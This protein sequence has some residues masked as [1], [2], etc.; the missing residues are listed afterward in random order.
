M[1]YEIKHQKTNATIFSGEYESLIK[2]AEAAVA[3]K[4]N[5]TD[6]DLM[7]ARL[8]GAN[9]TGANLMDAD[10]MD[11]N[12]ALDIKAEMEETWLLEVLA[13]ILPKRA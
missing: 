12:Q 6:A 7:G 10:L 3:G 11:A 9:L 13:A 5:L 2:C 1:L 8:M 4:G